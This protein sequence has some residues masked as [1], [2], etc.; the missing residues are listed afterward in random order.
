MQR[1]APP[2]FHTISDWN[3]WNDELICFKY[4]QNNYKIRIE[5]LQDSALYSSH[6][7]KACGL[8]SWEVLFVTV[9]NIL[10]LTSVSYYDGRYCNA[11]HI[12]TIL[13]MRFWNLYYWKHSYIISRD[14]ALFQCNL[15]IACFILAIISGMTELDNLY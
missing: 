8:T 6:I 12:T 10:Y 4:G 13:K 3:L 2:C 11:S 7:D 14:S 15:I 9:N 1:A 5:T